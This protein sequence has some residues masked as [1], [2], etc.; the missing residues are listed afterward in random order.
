MQILLLV[1]ATADGFAQHTA[2]KDQTKRTLVTRFYYPTCLI[3]KKSD[4]ALRLVEILM[5]YVF[6]VKLAVIEGP[7]SIVSKG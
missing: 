7:L 3:R 2:R 1:S 5:K 4:R 6:S